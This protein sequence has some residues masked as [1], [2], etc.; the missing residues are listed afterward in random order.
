MQI[1]IYDIM[2]FATKMVEY[3]IKNVSGNIEV[4]FFK[5]G[6]T[7]K[8]NDTHSGMAVKTLGLSVLLLKTKYPHFQPFRV[9]QRVM[10]GADMVPIL[11]YIGWSRWYWVKTKTGNSSFN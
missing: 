11:S 3:W 8:P 1:K 10:L 6:I 4:V 9:G 5:L 2:R 7:K